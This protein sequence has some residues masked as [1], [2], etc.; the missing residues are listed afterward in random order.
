MITNVKYANINNRG[1]RENDQSSNSVNKLINRKK[2]YEKLVQ[3]DNQLYQLYKNNG[4][5]PSELG[6]GNRPMKVRSGAYNG[7]NNE[8]DIQGKSMG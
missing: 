3:I 5:K 8:L 4:G 6:G 2:S 1:A 7:A